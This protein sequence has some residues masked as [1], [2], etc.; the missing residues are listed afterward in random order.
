MSL[1]P[2]DYLVL[3]EFLCTLRRL[4]S[5]NGRAQHSEQDDNPYRVEHNND[6]SREV[7]LRFV[8][9][10]YN[11]TVAE[12]EDLEDL[13]RDIKSLPAFAVHPLIAKMAIRDYF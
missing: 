7:V 2:D 12:I 8:C 6:V 11:T 13:F 5:A 3:G 9:A 10:R 4:G 1:V